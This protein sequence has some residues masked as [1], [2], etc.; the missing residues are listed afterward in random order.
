MAIPKHR[1]LELQVLEVLWAGGELSMREVLERLPPE[2]RPGYTTVRG[3]MYRLQE[4]KTIRRIRKVSSVQ[5]FEAAVS[6]NA[7][8]DGLIDDF[9]ELFGGDMRQVFARLIHTGRL[10]MSDLQ[11]AEKL[12][13]VG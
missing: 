5:I 9:A 3:V 12:A 13:S 1:K 11:D 6:R 4:R 7:V 2:N 8:C 10:T